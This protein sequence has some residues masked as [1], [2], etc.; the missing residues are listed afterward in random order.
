M[1]PLRLLLLAVL[2]AAAPVRAGE[3]EVFARPVPGAGET[4]KTLLIYDALAKPFSLANEVAVVST[5]LGRFQTRVE[6]RQAA[7]VSAREVEDA[8]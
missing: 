5:L 3:A 8:D 4:S 2:L 1:M 6:T 7:A